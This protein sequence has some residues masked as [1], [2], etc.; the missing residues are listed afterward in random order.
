MVNLIVKQLLEIIILSILLI[1]ISLIVC[2][3]I[4]LLI[5]IFNMINK[6]RGIRIKKA[7][8]EDLIKCGYRLEYISETPFADLE[9]VFCNIIELYK[10]D[11]L[12]LRHQFNPTRFYFCKTSTFVNYLIDVIKRH[13]AKNSLLLK[14]LLENVTEEYFRSY[15][16]DEV[17]Y[18]HDFQIY[19]YIEKKYGNIKNKEFTKLTKV[20]I[21]KLSYF[22]VKTYKELYSNVEKTEYKTFENFCVLKKYGQYKDFNFKL[23]LTEVLPEDPKKLNREYAN[24]LF[25]II[26]HIFIEP[27][28]QQLFKTIDEEI[29]REVI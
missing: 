23:K 7:L 15:I 5:N 18:Y 21:K 26:N 6:R 17:E 22:Y 19:D 28:L 4:K 14:E 2:L 16:L 11:K 20:Y 1:G 29:S 13:E 25:E 9:D 12:F 10:G 27:N 24:Y 3:F 8:D